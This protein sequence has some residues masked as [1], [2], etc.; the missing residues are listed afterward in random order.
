[1]TTGKVLKERR[2]PRER[3]RMGSGLTSLSY[4]YFTGFALAARLGGKLRDATA[5]VS[6]AMATASISAS[7][8]ASFSASSIR[9]RSCATTRAKMF[10]VHRSVLKRDAIKR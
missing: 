5:T 6:A 8:L 1:M 2:A 3:G 4:A 10:I 9:A 7:A